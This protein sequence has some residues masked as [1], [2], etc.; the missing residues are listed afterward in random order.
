MLIPLQP[1]S[2]DIP[3][4][5]IHW[6]RLLFDIVIAHMIHGPCVNLN[7]IIIILGFVEGLSFSEY[8]IEIIES[9]KHKNL[10]CSSIK[11]R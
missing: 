6:L 11:K 4:P 5:K 8:Q 3:D 2:A 7:M 1:I 9:W 10:K